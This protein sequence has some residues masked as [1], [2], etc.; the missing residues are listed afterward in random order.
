M[1]RN[2]IGLKGTTYNDWKFDTLNVHW[3]TAFLFYTNL[4]FSQ[5]F[6]KLLL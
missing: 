3:L 2:W 5:N 1:A 6:K 4:F